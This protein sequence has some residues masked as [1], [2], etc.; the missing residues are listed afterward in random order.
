M[1]ECPSWLTLAMAVFLI[2]PQKDTF[3]FRH[4]IPAHVIG[5]QP[6]FL[7]VS[8][9]QALPERYLNIIYTM[10]PN[11]T[12]EKP[13]LM[14]KTEFFQIQDERLFGEYIFAKDFS[15]RSYFFLIICFFLPVSK[16]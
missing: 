2:L 12:E 8:I 16:C 13:L 6:L 4:Y 3:A 1:V 7:V 15:Y 10:S 9:I 11:Q 5:V 14:H